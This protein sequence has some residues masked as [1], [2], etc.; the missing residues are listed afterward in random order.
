MTA[1]QITQLI[2]RPSDRI[3]VVGQTIAVG[4][5]EYK[6]EGVKHKKGKPTQVK[7]KLKNN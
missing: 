6:V 2:K 5:T 7:L 1:M 4:N 3:L